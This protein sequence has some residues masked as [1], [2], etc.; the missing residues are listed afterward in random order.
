MEKRV[1]LENVCS[2]K[3]IYLD[4]KVFKYIK[5]PR[6]EYEELDK[7]VKEIITRTRSKYVYPFSEAHLRDC[8]NKYKPEYREKVEED[9]TF[10][11]DVSERFCLA[12]RPDKRCIQP[13][14]QSITEVFDQVISLQNKPLDLSAVY[15]EMVPFEVKK[16]EFEN[17]KLVNGFLSAEKGVWDRSKMSELVERIFWECFASKATYDTVRKQEWKR[18]QRKEERCINDIYYNVTQK[19]LERLI[20]CYESADVEYIIRNWKNAIIDAI[21]IHYPKEEIS[22]EGLIC[23]AYCLLDWHPMY[24]DK[25]GKKN[26]FS[27]ITRDAKHVWYASQA[28]MF[29][30]EDKHTRKKCDVL[31]KSFGIKTKV[32]SMEE[33]EALM[34]FC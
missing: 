23:S 16:K 14:K 15:P 24:R 11:E 4:W 7:R 28:H 32:L 13:I 6:K 19:N 31:Y 25:L 29:V 30:T 2:R 10:T 18:Q 20:R 26:T 5:E 12:Y 9:L 33:F 27:N 17:D 3:Y 34:D 8:V 1:N 22:D 21:S